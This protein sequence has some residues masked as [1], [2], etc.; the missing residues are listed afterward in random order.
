MSGIGEGRQDKPGEACFLLYFE[1]REA[2]PTH[3]RWEEKGAPDG[4]V[5]KGPFS[6][7]NQ[8]FKAVEWPIMTAP[9]LAGKALTWSDP[10]SQS[11]KLV[12]GVGQMKVSKWPNLVDE[13]STRRSLL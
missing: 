9:S 8:Y 11:K 12:Q 7:R 6:A 13:T 3:K 5:V 2:P 4:G 1:P 10:K